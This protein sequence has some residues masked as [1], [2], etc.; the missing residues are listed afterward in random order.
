M[1]RLVTYLTGDPN[2]QLHIPALPFGYKTLPKWLRQLLGLDSPAM[3]FSLAQLLVSQPTFSAHISYS[4]V[5]A[6]GLTP[7]TT[8]GRLYNE[9]KGVAHIGTTDPRFVG[10]RMQLGSV[11]LRYVNGQ[12]G[13]LVVGDYSERVQVAYGAD[14]KTM[15]IIWPSWLKNS[16]QLMLGDK[17]WKAGVS[18]PVPVRWRCPIE[19]LDKRARRMIEVYEFLEK[20]NLHSVFYS[21]YAAEERVALLVLAALKF[22][23]YN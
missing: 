4:S 11:V 19:E 3:C 13:E 22:T 10:D 16:G 21:L 20:Q 1:I 6:E 5:L 7:A 23:G 18:V 14:T 8:A 9:G 2:W 17:D 15:T 12:T